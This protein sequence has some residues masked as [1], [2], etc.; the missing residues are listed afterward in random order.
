MR[1]KIIFFLKIL[2][3]ISLLLFLFSK[4]D[5]ANF[6][7]NFKKANGYLVFLASLF[8]YSGV[9]FSVLRWDI[10][11][12]FYKIL[13]RKTNLFK[14]YLIGTYFNNFLPSSIGGDGYKLYYLAKRMPD[15]KKEILS[16]MVFERGVGF[17]ILLFMNFL[18][19]LFYYKLIIINS[20]PIFAVEISLLFGF[21]LFLIFRKSVFT[22][23]DKLNF[24][25]NII[26]KFIDFLK[27]LFS[28]DDKNKL[29]SAIFYSLLFTFNAVV[30]AW[31]LF[32]SLG[33]RVSVFYILFAST[34]IQIL[35]I[36]PISINSIG[37]FE[38]ASI[39]VY[40][41]VGISP[42]ISL[43]VALISRVSMMITSSVGGIFLIRDD[44]I[45]IV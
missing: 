12:R 6:W 9:Y 31:L 32:L 18:L 42:E 39:F 37:I 33:V 24:K 35:G 34:F 17:L 14:I 10:F 29:I 16:S 3:S 36:L 4:I 43:A 1:K 22:G 5:F 21:I 19:F 25:I 30:G 28:F 7:D 2:I 13:I 40:S 20:K 27:V 15:K 26:N 41:I 8:F 38:G 44:K 45:K 11:L 23:L